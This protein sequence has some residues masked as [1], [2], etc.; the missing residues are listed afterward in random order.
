M[1]AV[2]RADWRSGMPASCTAGLGNILLMWPVDV[3][4]MCCSTTCSWHC[5][6][7]SAAGYESLC[8]VLLLQVSNRPLH[9]LYH[10]FSVNG[11][12]D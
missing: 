1:K 4:I 11:L 7:F 9:F 8:T 5:R 2:S 3:H 10:S 12:I 6:D